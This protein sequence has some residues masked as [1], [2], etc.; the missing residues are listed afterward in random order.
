M[1]KLIMDFTD[2]QDV[3]IFN[4]KTRNKK[5]VDKMDLLNKARKTL[6]QHLKKGLIANI[7]E[8]WHGQEITISWDSIWG[9]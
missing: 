9:N 1:G 5:Y 3:I 2:Q 7:S 8:S 4:P 6:N